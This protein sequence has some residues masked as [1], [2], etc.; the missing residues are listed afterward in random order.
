MF[1]EIVNC[2]FWPRLDTLMRVIFFAEGSAEVWREKVQRFS[3]D[4][5]CKGSCTRENELHKTTWGKRNCIYIYISSKLHLTNTNTRI[6]PKTEA[7]LYL[8]DEEEY[9]NLSHWH[10]NESPQR[11]WPP[12]SAGHMRKI[13]TSPPHTSSGSPA[14]ELHSINEVLSMHHNTEQTVWQLWILPLCRHTAAV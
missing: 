14:D 10:Y 6:S 9:L 4:E 5:P 7:L 11:P 1:A 8:E 3:E 13:S 2:V 12:I